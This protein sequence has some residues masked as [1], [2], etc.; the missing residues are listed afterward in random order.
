MTKTTRTRDSKI[1]RKHSRTYLC[2]CV[3]YADADVFSFVFDEM[4]CALHRQQRD[5]ERG[6]ELEQVR[7]VCDPF[8]LFF[9]SK[10]TPHCIMKISMYVGADYII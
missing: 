8:S 9:F 2:S 6:Q 1:S 7:R 5:I 3:V 10:N 4:S